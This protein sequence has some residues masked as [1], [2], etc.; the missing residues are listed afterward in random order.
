M[1]NF[2]QT[3]KDSFYSREFYSKIGGKPFKSILGYFTLLVLF[4][5]IIR[6]VSLY[7]PLV[8]NVPKEI[9]KG[10]EELINC[11]PDNLEVNISNGQATTSAR[12]PYFLSCDKEKSA[13]ESAFLVIDTG[14]TFSKEKFD[15][16]KTPI[17][18]TK[19]A[20]VAKKNSFETNTYSL[21]K[22]NNFKVN[23][24]EINTLY[25]KT[26]AYF[27]YVG[28]SLLSIASVL[29]YLGYIFRLVYLLIFSLLVFLISG[30]M[31][32]D[33][34][35]FQVYKTSVYAITPALLIELLL[36]LTRNW[37]NFNG[38]PFMIT[39]I[40]MGILFINLKSEVKP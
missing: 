22:I 20:L 14:T 8:N 11:Y 17:W 7:N 18:L 37:T 24:N 26:S 12:Q 32:K 3:I 4:L 33:F 13:S 5:T 16:Y 10:A 21:E 38:F 9:K 36:D 19:N 31:K 23:K 40:T 1:K 27:I 25:N 35:Y 30:L 39:V 6:A 28:P 15:E 29:I 34:S 2:F